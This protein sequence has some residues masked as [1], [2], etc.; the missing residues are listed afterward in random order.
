VKRS[1]ATRVHEGL[2]GEGSASAGSARVS[3]WDAFR[4]ASRRDLY[5]LFLESERLA[6]EVVENLPDE[7]IRRVLGFPVDADL[8]GIR[9]RLAKKIDEKRA[10]LKPFRRGKRGIARAEAARRIA[11]EWAEADADQENQQRQA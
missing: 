4:H 6:H 11:E 3:P 5:V 10:L 8:A 1:R 2:T 9:A 7:G